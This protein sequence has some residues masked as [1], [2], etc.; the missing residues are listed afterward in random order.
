MLDNA[1]VLKTSAPCTSSSLARAVRPY[2]REISLDR[3]GDLFQPH[4]ALDILTL[5]KLLGER[6][7]VRVVLRVR[8]KL[9]RALETQRE[10]GLRK[11]YLYDLNRHMNL[12]Y[13]LAEE[14]KLARNL[15]AAFFGQRRIAA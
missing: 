11:S 9:K 4:E 14:T 3:V 5:R 7:A 13:C 15:A 10:R 2:Q 1:S 8:R 6:D 12:A